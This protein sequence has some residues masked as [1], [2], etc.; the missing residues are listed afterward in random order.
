MAVGSRRASGQMRIAEAL[1]EHLPQIAALYRK[2]ALSTRLVSTITWGTRLVQ[3]EQALAIIDA[4][5]ADRAVNWER[6]SEDKLRVAVEM[7]VARY[8]P[9]ALRRTETTTRGRD[10]TIGACDDDTETMSVWG[11]L[12]TPA[13]AVMNQ[14]ITAMAQ[15]AVRQRSAQ[16]R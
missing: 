5:L 12:L 13:A 16:P 4:A 6:L 15:R 3:G 1:R 11:R 9:D 8:D 2:G 7:Q 14:R 10:F